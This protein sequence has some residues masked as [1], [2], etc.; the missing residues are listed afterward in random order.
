MYSKKDLKNLKN[1]NL[2]KKDIE[3]QLEN[4][5]KGFGYVKLSAYAAVGKGIKK[6][7]GEEEER[8]IKIYDENTENTDEIGRAH[9]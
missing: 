2:S 8:F 5:Q 3:L 6:L 7:S 4:F 1:R 9:V